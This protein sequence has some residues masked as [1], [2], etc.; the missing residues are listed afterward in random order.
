MQGPE[1]PN[2]HVERREDPELRLIDIYKIFI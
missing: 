1:T 2:G